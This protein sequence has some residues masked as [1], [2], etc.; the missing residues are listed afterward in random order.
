MKLLLS[1]S[2]NYTNFIDVDWPQVLNNYA[3]SIK[4]SNLIDICFSK[5]LHNS[6]WKNI[7]ANELA[8]CKRLQVMWYLSTRFSINL[9]Y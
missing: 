7:N 8:L 4:L 2:L 5:I 9:F 3:R 6:F 1:S